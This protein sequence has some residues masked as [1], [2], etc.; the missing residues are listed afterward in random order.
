MRGL[1]G[2]LGQ[3]LAAL[4]LLAAAGGAQA[5]VPLPKI[6]KAK[7]EKCVEPTDVMRRNHMKF[8]LHQ[9]DDT[10]RRGIRTKKHSLKE[11]LGCHVTAE[12]G[13][14]LPTAD[15]PD[16]FCS[17]CHRYAAVKIDCFGCHNDRPEQ[18]GQPLAQNPRTLPDAA[19]G[20]RVTVETLKVLATGEEAR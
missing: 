14:P 16:H 15:S 8:L 7:G 1:I 20:R 17:A 12:P 2:H 3:A 13:K 5:E 18:S 6:P 19:V 10:L 4:T 11:C 9:R